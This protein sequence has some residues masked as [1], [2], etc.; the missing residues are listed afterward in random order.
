M[1]LIDYVNIKHGTASQ[2]R[3][4]CGNTLPL[5]TL[6]HAL[7][8]FCLQTDA[9][10]G[11]WF[12]HPADRS[13]EGI[14]L[15]HRPSP[16][17][18]D[19]SFITFM[20]GAEN[21]YVSEGARW[22]GFRPEE[23][24]MRP[25]Y[26]KVKALRYGAT[27]SLAPTDSGAVMA[28]EY[29]DKICVPRFAVC[30]SDFQGEIT[31]D[32]EKREIFGYTTS[33]NGKPNREMPIYF[34]FSFGCDIYDL[35]VTDGICAKK[36]NY[37]KGNAAGANVA[38]EARH[39]EVKLAVSYLSIEQARYNLE[40]D[41]NKDFAGTKAEAE[42]KWEEVLSLIKVE[43][44]EESKK[45]FYS[46]LYRAF[47]YP[48]KYYETTRDGVNLHVNQENG[49]V[50]EGIMYTNNG[51]WDTYRTVYPLYSII[52]PEKCTEIVRGWL[53][54]YDDTGYLPRWPSP[55]EENCMPGTLVEAVIADAVVKG[56][57]SKK[58]C[59]RAL[60]AM[61]KNAEVQ[62]DCKKQGRKCVREYTEKG[63]VPY[64][65]CKESVNETLDCAYGDYCI[66]RVAE[67]LGEKEIA[68][69]YFARSSNY[70]NLFDARRGFMVAKDSEGNFKKDFDPVLWGGD[71]TE[72][73]A[74]QTTLA[75]P[76]DVNGLIEL[77]QGK[78]NLE[79]YVDNLIASE[80]YY[81]VG[82][83]GQEI[84]EMT[85]MAAVDFGLCAISNQPSFH[86]PFIYAEMGNKE[87]SSRL[88]HKIARNLFSPEDNGYPGDEDNG[89]M[90]CW[91]IFASIGLYPYCP[92]KGEYIVTEPIFNKVLIKVK[93]VYKDLTEICKGKNYIQHGMLA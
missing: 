64:D 56:L 82:S 3:F 86:I 66:A 13:F 47:L 87:K 9:S 77:F 62:S 26:L 69:K 28:L 92:A 22:S 83:Y 16:W 2:M 11:G 78:E 50:I 12:Y 43:G 79:R 46:C 67:Y 58:D 51:F 49:Q 54:F 27:I 75:V 7:A 57:L 65:L 73:C 63:Y 24:I 72:A 89:T 55:C 37:Y 1:S 39:T 70:K 6:P 15:T 14:R 20:P 19:F 68:K 90:A 84:H 32:P 4:S 81:K 76:H 21:P 30:P 31:I 88:V 33:N 23:A 29:D 80:P 59:E 10:R 35:Y 8:S 74:W 71:Y 25:D 42:R 5:V 36:G 60:V 48:T 17:I 61:R 41:A 91:Y 45:T 53:N 85:E 93:D 44:D 18:G 40:K 52:A 34:V 38:L